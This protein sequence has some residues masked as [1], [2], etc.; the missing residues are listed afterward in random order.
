[1]DF[2]TSFT[3][4]ALLPTILVFLGLVIHGIRLN[5]GRIDI[6]RQKGAWLGYLFVIG[7]LVYSAH[8]FWLVIDPSNGFIYKASIVTKRTLYIHYAMFPCIAAILWAMWYMERR[9]NRWIDSQQE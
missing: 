7:A 3:D 4:V 8:A 6:E 5:K 9:L 2:T 1:M